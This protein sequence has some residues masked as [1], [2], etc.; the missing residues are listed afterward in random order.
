M[1]L[2]TNQD[3]CKDIETQDLERLFKN[4]REKCTLRQMD[5]LDSLP[6][7]KT[8]P[9]HSKATRLIKALEAVD[10]DAALAVLDTK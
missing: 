8:Q 1:R 7:L 9:A 3:N 4:I 10:F 6:I 5:V 2:T